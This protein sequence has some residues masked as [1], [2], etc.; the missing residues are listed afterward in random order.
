MAPTPACPLLYCGP[1]SLYLQVQKEDVEL[2]AAQFDLDKKK[3]ERCLREAQ[4]DV[5]AA[6]QSLLAA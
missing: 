3:A 1:L 2:I 4:G 6:L 5:K